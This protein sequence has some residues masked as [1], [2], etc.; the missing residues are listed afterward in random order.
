MIIPFTKMH[1]LGND[2][3]VINNLESQYQFPTEY[4]A[5][6][7]NRHLGIGFDQLLLIERSESADYFCRIYNADGSEAEQCGNGLRCVALYI[8]K[9]NL[10]P[11]VNLAIET[12]SGIFSA[13]F[14]SDDQIRVSLG[15]PIVENKLVLLDVDNQTL[16]ATIL[17]FGNPHAII[18][19]E[20]DL[21][22]EETLAKSIS[23]LAL[24]PNGV[25]VG[26]MQVIN[27]KHIRLRT[28]ERG[29]GETFACGSNA[30]AAAVAGLLNGWLEA[31]VNIEYKYG[32]L[33]IIVDQEVKRVF[34]T[35]PATIV[36]EG[37]IRT[38]P[39]A[40]LSIMNLRD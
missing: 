4:I 37:V 29:V 14:L 22:V 6:L 40:S 20:S 8:H 10:N 32:S 9:H 30:C 11:S 15:N 25:N 21:E 35:G 19:M 38:N 23:K 17:S 28:F 27:P 39:A 1:G 7:A 26:F 16:P 18:K 33:N 31:S 24:F 36:Y 2:F 34:L 12:K 13:E 5:K 3:V